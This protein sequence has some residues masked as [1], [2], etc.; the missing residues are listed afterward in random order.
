MGDEIVTQAVLLLWGGIAAGLAIGGLL[1]WR[2]GF[3]WGLGVGC[4]VIGVGGLAGAGHL[5]WHRWQA[6]DGTVATTGVLLGFSEETVKNT[7]GR[8]LTVRVPLVGFVAQDGTEHRVRGLGGSQGGASPGDPVAVRYRPEDPSQAIV[9]DAQNL[10]AGVW[11]LGMFGIV[12]LLFGIAATPWRGTS[13]APQA[14]AVRPR[15]KKA[16]R[17]SKA[18]SRARPPPTPMTDDALPGLT[19]RQQRAMTLSMGV[20]H[21]LMVGSFVAAW[22]LSDHVGHAVAACFT[23]ITPAFFA[24]GVGSAVR[25]GTWHAGVTLV[26]AGVVFLLFA[27]GLWLFT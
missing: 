22:I 21:G 10:W 18:A 9:A 27:V 16:V 15:G 24:Y 1:G 25:N 26:M 14:M 11:G 7:D 2:A 4:L 13:D 19:P 23:V 20:G 17:A 6:I 5:G 12:P 8:R 3:M